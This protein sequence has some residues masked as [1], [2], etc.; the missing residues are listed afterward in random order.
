M[1]RASIPAETPR[2]MAEAY[3]AW[4]TTRK[5]GDRVASA[6]AY[7]VFEETRAAA[8]RAGRMD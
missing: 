4:L 5:S 6:A 7:K 1:A 8:I 3:T 2:E